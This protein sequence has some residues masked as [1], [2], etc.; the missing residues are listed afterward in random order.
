MTH[1][2][3]NQLFVSS[4]DDR[5]K[6]GPPACRVASCKVPVPTRGDKETNFPYIQSKIDRLETSNKGNLDL[7]GNSM[8]LCESQSQ[9]CCHDAAMCA[10]I[11]GI[12][13]QKSKD[14]GPSQNSMH[15]SWKIQPT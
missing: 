8:E 3:V 4:P 10:S 1:N 9:G 13:S 5:T 6:S 11:R 7:C 2:R 12:S 15:A 14:V